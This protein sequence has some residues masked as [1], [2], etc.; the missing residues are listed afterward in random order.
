MPYNFKQLK[1]SP[2]QYTPQQQYT[3]QEPIPN[4]SYDPR[5]ASETRF[6][7]YSGEQFQSLF[8]A[9]NTLGAN[10]AMTGEMFTGAPRY[11]PYGGAR[12]DFIDSV[13]KTRQVW[14]NDANK[15]AGGYVPQSYQENVFD[16]Q[17]YLDAQFNNMNNYLGKLGSYFGNM[18]PTSSQHILTN[19]PFQGARPLMPT[20]GSNL[21]LGGSTGGTNINN[22]F[23]SFG[24]GAGGGWGTAPTSLFGAGANA[25][26][27]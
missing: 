1:Y 12:D 26:I 23:P 21:N 17:G 13:T 20:V 16:Q 18:G 25:T 9:I 6:Q 19:S 11:S 2:Y 22:P 5:T 15:Q 10:P 4:S 24:V 7:D 27:P 14:D 3:G 8:D